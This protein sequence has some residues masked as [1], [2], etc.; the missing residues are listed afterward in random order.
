MITDKEIATYWRNYDLFIIRWFCVSFFGFPLLPLAYIGKYYL[1]GKNIW[2]LND[3]KDGDFGDPAEL[4][5]AGRNPGRTFG[6]FMWWWF[7]N[8]SWNYNRKF[9][10]NWNGGQAEDFR[11]IRT[12]LTN[13]QI[14][15]NRWAWCYQ[16]GWHGYHYIAARINGKIECRFSEA[17][18][19]MQRQMGSG[20]NEYRFRFKGIWT[21][22]ANQ[23]KRI[24]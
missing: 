23:I 3:T 12:S 6:N 7:R 14:E 1:G 22:F 17:N 2:L 19:K 13:E 10:P 24:F 21:I 15:R 8:H 4:R 20:G 16:N 11:I 5:K 18:D 9:I